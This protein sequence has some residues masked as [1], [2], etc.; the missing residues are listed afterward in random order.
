MAEI[1]EP[2]AP[3]AVAVDHGS[4]NGEVQGASR[5]R[6]SVAL[7][8]SVDERWERSYRMIQMEETGF[9]RFRLEPASKTVSFTVR[10]GDGP[11]QVIS[12]LERLD[13]F[14]EMV[15]RSASLWTGA[16]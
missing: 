2:T 15:N 6:Y 13:T 11:E 7:I 4:L 9:F 1:A 3:Y 12:I 8:G 14:V 16:A 5:T 10:A